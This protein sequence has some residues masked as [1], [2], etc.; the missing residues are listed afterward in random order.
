MNTLIVH[1]PYDV[2]TLRT[3]QE[4][5]VKD[6]AFDLRA[7]SPNLITFAVLTEILEGLQSERIFLS[8]ENEKK[9][10]VLASLDLLKKWKEKMILIYRDQQEADYYQGIDLPFLWMFHPV[11]DWRSIL[12]LGHIRGIILPLKWQEQYQKLPELWKLIDERHLEVYLHADTFEEALTL[13]MDQQLNFSVDL[14]AEVE[15]GHR[16][17]DQSRLKAMKFWRKRNESPAF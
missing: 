6:F 14:G 8:F 4:L 9:A 12:K 17:V 15:S 1:G 2:T 13:T 5:G 11:A 10:T 7:R 16:K 3:L